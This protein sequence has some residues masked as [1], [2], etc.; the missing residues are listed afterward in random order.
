MGKF[1]QSLVRLEP[2]PSK[3]VLVRVQGDTP[4]ALKTETQLA[5]KINHGMAQGEQLVASGCL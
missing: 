3:F 4:P 5:L 2:M 1:N